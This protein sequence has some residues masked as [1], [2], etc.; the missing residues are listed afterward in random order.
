MFGSWNGAVVAF[1]SSVSY[2]LDIAGNGLY[3]KP[4]LQLRASKKLIVPETSLRR[5][6]GGG[7]FSDTNFNLFLQDMK[8]FG[9]H[10]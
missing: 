5:W 4:C 2:V 6:R 8:R 1:A 7:R 9:V 10:V 3:I